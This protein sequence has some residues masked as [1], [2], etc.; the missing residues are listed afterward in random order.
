[1]V[2]YDNNDDKNNIDHYKND[3]Y[4]ADKY[5]FLFALLTNI[6]ETQSSAV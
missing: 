6:S 3:N 5:L 4:S 1:M 2:D